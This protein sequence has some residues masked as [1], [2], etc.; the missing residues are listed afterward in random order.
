M[1]SKE[2]VMSVQVVSQSQHSVTVQITISVEGSMLKVEEAIQE[3]LNEAGLVVTEHKLS[4]FDTDGSPLIFGSIKLTSRGQFPQEY[5]TPY[6]TAIVLRH[7]YQ[8]NQGGRT[9]CPVED[10]ARLVLN[11]TPRFA[12]LISFKYAELGAEKVVADVLESHRRNI[13]VRYVKML[14]DAVGMMALA[15]EE[16]W[17]YSLPEWEDEV[18]SVGVG[19]DGAYMLMKDDGWREAMAG[20]ISLYNSEGERLH[21]I[22]VGATP[23]YG[24]EKFRE[25]FL[26][27][28]NRVKSACGDIPY[29]GLGD[30]AKDNWTFLT[31]HTNEQIL[32]FFHASEYVSNVASVLFK[33]KGKNNE[34]KSWLQERLHILKHE[35][36]GSEKL[37]KEMEQYL[38]DKTRKPRL[39]KG[40]LDTISASITYFANQKNRME[41][42]RYRESGY[43]IGSGV[44]EATCKTLIK[45]RFCGS[46][47]RWKDK[48]ASFV[49]AIRALRLTTQR[50]QQ[51][52]NKID[53]QG[54][55]TIEKSSVN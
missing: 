40:D 47:A 5:E 38:G 32:D 51:F 44:T 6:G 31:Q 28:L 25:R 33:G 3:A 54:C 15:K 55:P 18:A 12:K 35:K 46:G 7:V 48:G 23:E 22:C 52:W 1:F 14:G 50:W 37:R 10:R 45:S 26:R 24:K 42:W 39:A 29:V 21:T 41:Y 8:S 49:L 17:E 36:G 11:S 2:V 9:Y 19:V 20:S 30:G 27:E 13:S 34:R 16:T 4:T 53:Q 43:P